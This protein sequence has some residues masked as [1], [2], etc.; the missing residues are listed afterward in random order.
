MIKIAVCGAAGRMGGRIIAAIT[1]GEECVPPFTHGVL[2]GYAF[3]I[4]T[5]IRAPCDIESTPPAEAA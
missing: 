4:P 3:T 5:V 2:W 1:H